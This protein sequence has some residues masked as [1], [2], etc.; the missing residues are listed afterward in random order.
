MVNFDQAE[1][2][3]FL[4]LHQPRSTVKRREA[5]YFGLGTNKKAGA[6]FVLGLLALVTAVVTLVLA[7][8]PLQ[9]LPFDQ[10]TALAIMGGALLLGLML[11]LLARRSLLRTP[12]LWIE[13]GC[14]SCREHDM[15]RIRRT[16]QDRMITALGIPVRRYACRTCTWQGR[17]VIGFAHFPEP[18]VAMPEPDE[19][20]FAEADEFDL[21]PE[22]ARLAEALVFQ[23]RSGTAEAETLSP[24]PDPFAA[25]EDDLFVSAEEPAIVAP[26]PELEE[27]AALTEPPAAEETAVDNQLVLADQPAEAEATWMEAFEE[28][29]VSAEPSS[30]LKDVIPYNPGSDTS[31]LGDLPPFEA[32]VQPES[33]PRLEQQESPAEKRGWFARLLHREP[34]AREI[35]ESPAM[36]AA[37]AAFETAQPKPSAGIEILDAADTDEAKVEPS[38]EEDDLHK[39]IYNKSRNYD[40]DEDEFDPDFERLCYEVATNNGKN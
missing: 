7:L 39:V 2:D 35:N 31:E 17:Q 40:P 13:T 25:V 15:I 1:M 19:V 37:P 38:S 30:D 6:L 32:I 22:L 21:D 34:E 5:K 16:S 10:L 27:I 20:D 3:Q 33:L 28:T 11:L 9:L 23:R 14:P 26:A 8:L 24:A 18:V 12:Q 4:E 36:Q 29:A